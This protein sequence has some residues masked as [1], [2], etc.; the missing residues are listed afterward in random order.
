MRIKFGFPTLAEEKTIILRNIL[1]PLDKIENTINY[2][3]ITYLIEAVKNV[4]I[5]EDVM[6][7][8]VKIVHATRNKEEVIL[9][10]SPRGSI[11]LFKA[12]QAYAA[13]NGRD[14]IMPEDVKHMAPFI[15]NHRIAVRGVNTLEGSIAYVNT[16]L[17]E[18]PVPIEG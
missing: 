2:E 7:Y 5:S 17:E 12:C 14:Y 18:I 1:D 4:R 11:A 13:I 9:E 8:L 3:D 16:M 10:V 15:L 6:D